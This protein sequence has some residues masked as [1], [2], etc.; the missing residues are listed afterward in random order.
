[1]GW[2][3]E[4]GHRVLVVS[5]EGWGLIRIPKLKRAPLMLRSPG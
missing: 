1:M 5:G 4:L 2:G 3:V